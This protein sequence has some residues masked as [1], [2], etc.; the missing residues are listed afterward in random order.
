MT[1][2]KLYRVLVSDPKYTPNPP[3]EVDASRQL[4]HQADAVLRAADA[5][6]ANPPK[7]DAPAE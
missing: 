6:V 5:F 7:P 1:L 2:L 3:T 4:K